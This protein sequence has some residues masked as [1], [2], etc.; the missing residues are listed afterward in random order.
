MAFPP[1][2]A[3]GVSETEVDTKIATHK[4]D[5]SAHHTRYTDGEAIAAC[6][7]AGLALASGKNIKL[8]SALTAN[9]SWSGISVVLTAGE[10][11]ALGNC[12]YLK[13]SDSRAWKALATATTTMPAIALATC[14]TIAGSQYEFLLL[15]FMRNDAWVWTPGGLL[16]ISR[17]TAGLLTQT[18]PAIVGEQV[19]VAGLAITATIILWN[20]S[21]ELV[22]IA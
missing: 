7:A 20:P 17:A 15:G 16:Y 6:E 3:A 11:L 10:V 2:G 22:E 18:L 21:Y 8:I 14:A 13:G 19:Q 12:V 1:Q 4:S 5:A 9:L